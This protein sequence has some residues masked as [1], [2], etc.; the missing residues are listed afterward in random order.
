MTE[1]VLIEEILGKTFIVTRITSTR[2]NSQ[3]LI[4]EIIGK[5]FIVTR[6]TSIKKIYNRGSACQNKCING[7]TSCQRKGRKEMGP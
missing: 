7:E 5:I 6:M 3:L 1:E 2:K 4:E